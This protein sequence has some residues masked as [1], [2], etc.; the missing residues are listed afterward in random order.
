MVLSH[1]T[2]EKH[3]YF[4]VQVAAGRRRA[5]NVSRAMLG[6]FAAAN[7][8]AGELMGQGVQEVGEVG[9]KRHVA[10]FRVKGEEG[11]VPVGFKVK[12]SWFRE[13]DFVD[14]RSVSR[15]MGFEG[16]SHGFLVLFFRDGWG[17]SRRG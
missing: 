13:G 6:H 15:G 8:E 12:A 9:V 1:K 17:E 10:E 5:Q 2:R 4:A 14:A 7:A 16:V 11:L 3:G